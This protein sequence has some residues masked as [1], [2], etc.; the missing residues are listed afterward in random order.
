MG[1]CLPGHAAGLCSGSVMLTYFIC[2]LLFFSDDFLTLV[3]NTATAAALVALTQIRVMKAVLRYT[4]CAKSLPAIR[5][6]LLS[7]S[8]CYSWASSSVSLLAYLT[9]LL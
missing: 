2:V 4:E 3:R 9:S 6:N 5:G 8:S 1:Y 7:S